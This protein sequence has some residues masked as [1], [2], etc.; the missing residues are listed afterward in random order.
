ML[1]NSKTPLRRTLRAK[2]REIPAEI[3]QHAAQ[4]VAQLAAQNFSLHRNKRVAIYASLDEELDT[5]PLIEI[6][7]KRGCQIFLP[8]IYVRDA[9]ME[10][11]AFTREQRRNCFGIHEPCST[12]II[13]A[14][15][16]DLVFVPLVAFDLCGTRLGMGGGYYDRAF[17]FRNFRSHW[18]KPHLVGIAYAFQ[19]VSTLERA[20]HDVLLDAVIT[21]VDV[22]F[23]HI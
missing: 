22:A 21:D 6:L 19:H 1:T 15:W 10:F 9:R 8:R 17:A 5:A 12:K 16:L 18:C 4:R 20:P 13:A 3:R 14:R 23:K 11:V 7:L 2:R